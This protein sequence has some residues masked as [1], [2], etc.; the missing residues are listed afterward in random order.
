LDIIH[1]LK[2]KIL[3]ITTLQRLVLSPPSGKH[4]MGVEN[5]YSEIK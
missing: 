4:R 3:N 1:C 2:F 5:K